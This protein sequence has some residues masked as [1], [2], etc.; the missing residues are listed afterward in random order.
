MI[1]FANGSPAAFNGSQPAD[2]ELMIGQMGQKMGGIQPLLSQERLGRTVMFLSLQTQSSKG[3]SRE[4]SDAEW[5]MLSSIIDNL[6]VE[7]I[8]YRRHEL[9]EKKQEHGHPSDF[10]FGDNWKKTS[11]D[12]RVA[13]DQ[14]LEE[15][16]EGGQLAVELTN[17]G[18]A[19][20]Y[21]NP[22]LDPTTGRISGDFN[23]KLTNE[24]FPYR[25]K[26]YCAHKPHTPPDERLIYGPTWRTLSLFWRQNREAGMVEGWNY[27]G[28]K[29]VIALIRCD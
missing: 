24:W 27:E 8:S 4:L 11:L 18:Q 9:S 20:K 12:I 17:S 7:W 26:E 15:M 14:Q 22:P 23:Q 16:Y 28:K 19:D 2:W 6:K 5:K 13:L 3:G 21:G 1:A 29:G 10:I 25:E